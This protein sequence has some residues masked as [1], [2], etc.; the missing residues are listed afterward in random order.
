MPTPDDPLTSEFSITT[1]EI[2]W[3]Y[4]CP[5]VS[6][7]KPTRV[8]RRLLRNPRTRQLR[9]VT[10]DRSLST[11]VLTSIP[12]P[13]AGAP[14]RSAPRQSSVTFDAVISNP[15]VYV[16]RESSTLLL[17]MV[18]RTAACEHPIRTGLGCPGGGGR[19]GRHAAVASTS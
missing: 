18:T 11:G 5:A 6:V 16:H 15:A 4:S 17:V 13:F 10:P 9:I 19:I 3:S 12:T 7:R 14:R 2:P 1:P 8:T